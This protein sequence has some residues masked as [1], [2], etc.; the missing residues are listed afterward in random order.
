MVIE[1]AGGLFGCN[2]GNPFDDPLDTDPPLMV[3]HG[4][5]DSTVPF[6]F[7]TAL[8]DFANSAGLPLDFQAVVNGGHVPGLGT[9]TATTG[10]T[11]YQRTVGYHHE[12]VFD[13]LEEG[14]QPPLPSGC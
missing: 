1:Q 10:V 12:T 3:T 5:N 13:G 11:L 4:T 8:Q 7:A 6:L 2:I 14:P 9:N